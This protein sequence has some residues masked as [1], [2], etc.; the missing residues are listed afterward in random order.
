LFRSVDSILRTFDRKIK[1]L[2]TLAEK[3]AAAV[4]AAHA[5]VVELE[6]HKDHL[7]QEGARAQSVAIRIRELIG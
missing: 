1:Q 7:T 5:R 4:S 2:E 6:R 3:H